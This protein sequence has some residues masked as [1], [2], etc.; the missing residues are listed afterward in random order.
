MT[1]T[2]EIKVTQL[3]NSLDFD[4]LAK[5]FDEVDNIEITDMILDRMFTLDEERA[6]EYSN[7]Y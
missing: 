2:Q 4:G 6:I 5:A 1:K 3:I 7:N